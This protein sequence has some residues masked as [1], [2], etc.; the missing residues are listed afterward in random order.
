MEEELR[1]EKLI[2]AG[3]NDAREMFAKANVLMDR[4][5]ALITKAD[6]ILAEGV[7]VKV[8]PGGTIDIKPASNS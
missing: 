8:G 3:L 1:Q 4:L 7:S 6:K 5:D 2:G